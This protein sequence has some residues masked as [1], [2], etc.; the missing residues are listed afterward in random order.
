MFSESD[1]VQGFSE[2]SPSLGVVTD[3]FVKAVSVGADTATMAEVTAGEGEQSDC[4]MVD[5]TAEQ[6]D[7]SRMTRLTVWEAPARELERDSCGVLGRRSSTTGPSQVH[8]VVS[9]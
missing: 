2:E 3:N 1:V 4:S 7:A 5:L 9:I 6:E 8:G